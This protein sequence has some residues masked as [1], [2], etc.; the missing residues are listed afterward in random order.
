MQPACLASVKETYTYI[1]QLENNSIENNGSYK[2]ERIWCRATQWCLHQ[3][4][5]ASSITNMLEDLVWC[6]PEQRW[7]DSWLMALMANNPQM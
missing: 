7:I 1:R 5:N 6:I 2:I 4:N 3:Y